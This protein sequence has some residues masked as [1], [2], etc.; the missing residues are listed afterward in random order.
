[1]KNL[2][3]MFSGYKT[4]NRTL[5]VETIDPQI[6]DPVVGKLNTIYANIIELFEINRYT[7]THQAYKDR[8]FIKQINLLDSVL[9]DRFGFKVKHLATENLDYFCMPV[10]PIHSNIMKP[11]AEEYY[12]Y[13]K[14]KLTGNIKKDIKD[15]NSDYYDQGDVFNTIIKNMKA[16]TDKMNSDGVTV[17][18]K[19][20]YISG[21]PN[22]FVIFL[23]C[24]FYF[25]NYVIKVSAEQYTAI[26][27]HEIGHA[28]SDIEYSYRVV[29]STAVLLDSINT[30]LR[31]KNK[32]KLDTIIIAYE[33]TFGEKPKT[34]KPNTINVTIETVDRLLKNYGNLGSYS[35]SYMDSENLA[36]LFATRFGMG[37]TSVTKNAKYDELISKHRP[38]RLGVIDLGIAMFGMAPVCF[39]I[40]GPLGA[41]FWVSIVSCFL[42]S[43]YTESR[44]TTTKLRTHDEDLRRSKR[45]R[46]DM[47]RQIRLYK[48]EKSV[49]DKMMSDIEKIDLVISTMSRID[50]TFLDKLYIKYNTFGAKI[51]ELKETEQLIEDLMENDL[52]LSSIKLKNLAGGKKS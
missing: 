12:E 51:T 23:G 32:S 33:D 49:V 31:N 7:S 29:Q 26:V 42:T 38:R 15:M 39:I 50:K 48:L 17:D 43:L 47:V 41:I 36:D 8:N 37:F 21:L 9:S 16:L 2:K 30:N 18:N 3:D 28:Y 6:N 24:D 34:K 46:N 1:M 44:D 45:V 14:N 5:S 22:D 19:K 27:L 35:N 11:M 10:S 52:Y 40:A 20:A 13:W 25:L 4:E